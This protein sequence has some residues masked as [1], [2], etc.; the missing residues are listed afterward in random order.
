MPEV[1]LLDADYSTIGVLNEAYTSLEIVEKYQGV[2][3]FKMTMA[4]AA[5]YAS[6]IQ[7]G[8]LLYL[9]REDDALFLI[10]QIQEDVDEAR[11]EKVV[12]GR[13]VDGFALAERRVDATGIDYDSQIGVAAETAMKHYVDLHA[14][15]GAPIA[16]QIPG[17]VIGT[18]LARGGPIEY[19][20]RFQTLFTVLSEIGR[21]SGLGWRAPFDPVSGQVVFDAL[22]G[23][24][25]TGSVFFDFDFETLR[26]WTRLDSIADS[27]TFA[28]V[29]GQGELAAR[30][31]VKRFL[32]SEPSGFARREDF[33]DARDVE[34]GNTAVLEVRG[35]AFLASR[36]P[37]RSLEATINEQGSFKFGVH[38]FN[39]DIVTIRN[40]D[41]GLEY[42]AR[43]LEVHRTWTTS[44]LFPETK[45]VL[46]RAIPRWKDQIERV[47]GGVIPI[48]DMKHGGG[49]GICSIVVASDILVTYGAGAGW[50]V[51]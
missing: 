45:S 40:E 38:W 46:D 31:I 15:P 12:A 7:N 13:S 16:R 41:R 20:A 51:V 11:D 36:G 26:S 14:G 24:D 43:V 1:F 23:A 37:E 2:D 18:D 33:V 27:K 47:A 50:V 25:R 28:I 6:E 10:E 4:S 3:S 48:V 44:A 19:T 49:D 22:E 17:L 29:A 42:A 5:L 34:L 9:P 35:D 21:V 39:G 8:R 30:D 32:G